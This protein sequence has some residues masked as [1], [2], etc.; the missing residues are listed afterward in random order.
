MGDG[1]GGGSVRGGCGSG[2]GERWE[3]LGEDGRDGGGGGRVRG[4]RWE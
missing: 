2:R 4:G 3:W 1:S